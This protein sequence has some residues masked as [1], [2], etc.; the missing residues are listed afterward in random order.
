MGTYGILQDFINKWNQ[1]HYGP[2]AVRVF[3]DVSDEIILGFKLR[4]KGARFPIDGSTFRRL[5]TRVYANSKNQLRVTSKPG[6][7]TTVTM[8]KKMQYGSEHQ[9]E[10]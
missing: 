3:P 7:G 2:D 4:F 5:M 6:K 1:E 8:R 10:S 9:T